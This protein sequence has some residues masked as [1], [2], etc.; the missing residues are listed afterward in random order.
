MPEAYSSL[1]VHG[2]RVIPIA[3]CSGRG[4]PVV[5]RVPFQTQPTYSLQN[6]HDVSSAV[7]LN[8]CLCH[9]R[10]ALT[11]EN[12]AIRGVMSRKLLLTAYSGDREQSFH[13]M[14][15]GAW[16]RLLVDSFLR[17]VFTIRQVGGVVL[18]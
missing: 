4:S 10:A 14:V 15:N 9:P 5:D 17:Q 11:L 8:N 18:C 12:A 6:S 3:Q 16:S 2:S 1:G 7:G 13:A